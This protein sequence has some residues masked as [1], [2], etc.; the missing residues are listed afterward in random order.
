[1]NILVYSSVPMNIVAY[2]RGRYIHRLLRQLTEEYKLRSSVIELCSSV[3]TEE[4]VMVSY[5]AIAYVF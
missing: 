2:I 5:S 1:M 4:R 3:I